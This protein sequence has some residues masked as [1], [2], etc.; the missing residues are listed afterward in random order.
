VRV[1]L[2]D[3]ASE[4]AWLRPQIDEAIA[5][6][7]D[8]G[9]LIGGPEV[10]SFEAELAPVAG[11]AC[12]VGISSG[13]DALLAALWA[14]GVGPGDEVVTTPFTFF[15]T[16]GAIWRLG[17]RPV[18]AD[19]EPRSMN[20]DPRRAAA[21]VGARTRAILPVHLFGR[22]AKIPQVGDIPVIED[23][24]QSVG[25]APLRGVAAALSF[26]PTKNLGAL[27]DA[28]AVV[29]RDPALAERVG[30]L[31]AHGARP[32]YHHEIVGANLRLDAL[33]AAVLRV[34]LPH[35]P[36]FT[37]ARRARAERYRELFATAPVPPEI[38][39]P[40]HDP[41]HVYNQFVIR[42]PR[43]DALHAYLTDAGIA[44]AVYYPEPLH[45]QPCFAELGYQPGAFP[46][47]EAAAR[48]ALALP[49]HPT[50]TAQMQVRVVEAVASFFRRPR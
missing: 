37:N 19:I 39:L 32:K 29:T 41:A 12:A 9:Q 36:H 43:R 4:I 23:A 24:A 47:A 28:G 16:A 27:G 10:A 40:A 1:P 17:A 42:A 34:K 30:L 2:V 20:L 14:L 33:Q 6:V 13:S 7:L 46:E 38:K 26:F 22:P 48:E 11:A 25:A 50:I 18:F 5:R 15:A 45:L 49:V 31:R 3:I 44:T 21:A 35:L 8:G